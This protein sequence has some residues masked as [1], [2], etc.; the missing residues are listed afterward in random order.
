MPFN[1]AMISEKGYAIDISSTKEYAGR[2]GKTDFFQGTLGSKDIRRASAALGKSGSM[3]ERM[4]KKIN[5]YVGL[6][7]ARNFAEG[8]DSNG[9]EWEKLSEST[10]RK[11][12]K[13]DFRDTRVVVLSK[14]KSKKAR[15][16]LDRLK[17]NIEPVGGKFVVPLVETGNLF[18]SVTTPVT[19]T[20]D[21]GG[22]T[23][24]DRFKV[25]G[26][27]G[28]GLVVSERQ[29]FVNFSPTPKGKNWDMKF[30]VH[31]KPVGSSTSTGKSSVPGREFFYVSDSVLE[32]T[33]LLI[34]MARL[35]GTKQLKKGTTEESTPFFSVGKR[36]F[37]PRTTRGQ[38]GGRYKGE[39]GRTP[40][41][42]GRVE[43]TRLDFVHWVKNG[44]R[45]FNAKHL[46]L[47]LNEKDETRLLDYFDV[48]TMKILDDSR[49]FAFMKAADAVSAAR[50]VGKKN[51]GKGNARLK[52]A[53]KA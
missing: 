16:R 42:G 14:D 4:K 23:S 51:R 3:G 24:G 6:E 22:A 41:R 26:T 47:N 27:G 50:A 29:K 2:Q 49:I 31:N 7:I 43:F 30:E 38:S 52:K 37:R 19:R 9:R 44:S 15:M 17:A 53:V 12:T 13:A 25:A 20:I 32:F 21:R 1:L 34:G 48:E 5:A 36:D 35:V 8:K 40:G 45:K 10:I 46:G 28:V 18:K 33:A 11:K 39:G